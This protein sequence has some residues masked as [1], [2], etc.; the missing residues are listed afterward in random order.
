VKR[1]ITAVPPRPSSADAQQDDGGLERAGPPRTLLWWLA[2]GV[3]TGAVALGAGP[4]IEIE[5]QLFRS[6]AHD[7]LT[8]A[9]PRPSAAGRR[10]VDGDQ[11]A[12]V[13]CCASYSA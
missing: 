11:M 9:R 5:L 10:R 7:R 6:S 1:E 13:C 2:F 4:G 8:Q 3:G 12:T